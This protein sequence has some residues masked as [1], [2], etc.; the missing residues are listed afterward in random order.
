VEL[1]EDEGVDCAGTEVGQSEKSGTG[2]TRLGE[3][4]GLYFS[5]VAKGKMAS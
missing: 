3:P 4:A 2:G 5:G 1:G